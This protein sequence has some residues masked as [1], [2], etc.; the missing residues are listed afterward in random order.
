M[1]RHARTISH[2]E[3]LLLNGQLHVQQHDSAAAELAKSPVSDLVLPTRRRWGN[4]LFLL[5]FTAL[6]LGICGGAVWSLVHYFDSIWQS[7]FVAALLLGGIAFALRY[8]AIWMYRNV[9]VRHF[10]TTMQLSRENKES[11]PVLEWFKVWLPRYMKAQQVQFNNVAPLFRKKDGTT[12]F[13]MRKSD[14]FALSLWAAQGSHSF[15]FRAHDGS[16]SSVLMSYYTKG[17]MKKTGWNN[18]LVAQEYIDLY[19]F[20]PL[21]TRLRHLVEMLERAQQAYGEKEEGV[22]RFQR[23]EWNS[24]KEMWESR[25]ADEPITTNFSSL[26]FYEQRLLHRVYEEVESFLATP[27]ADLLAAGLPLKIGPPSRRAPVRHLAARY[28]LDINIIDMN[29]GQMNNESLLQCFNMA[30]GI[31]LLEDVDN[32][33]AAIGVKSA[34]DKKEQHRVT[35]DGLLNALDGVQRG[36]SKRIIIATTNYP[37]KLMP[38]IRRRG[39][40]GLSFEITYPSDATLGRLLRHHLPSGADVADTTAR[41]RAVETRLGLP[42]PTAALTDIFAKA[43]LRARLP[44]AA[45]DNGDGGAAPPLDAPLATEKAIEEVEEVLSE[46]VSTNKKVFKTIDELLSFLH[47]SD[48]WTSGDREAS[49]LAWERVGPEPPAAPVYGEAPRELVSARLSTGL[50]RQE[51]GEITREPVVSSRRLS[52]GLAGKVAKASGKAE[53]GKAPSSSVAAAPAETDPAAEGEGGEQEAPA[54]PSLLEFSDEEWKR[55]QVPSLTVERYVRVEG[56]ESGGATVYYR[57]VDDDAKRDG[58]PKPY[59]RSFADAGCSSAL[60]CKKLDD[61]QLKDCLS[62]G[63]LGHRMQ[64]LEQFRFL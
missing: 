24:W 26:V 44:R 2:V 56:A 37:E 51:G 13:T 36:A 3:P 1:P 18:E 15:V 12:F 35:L 5:I 53:G 64:L 14:Q 17:E 58:R 39:R 60:L 54:D 4:L 20:D 63:A 55:F 23:R 62:I 11:T 41:L 40:L 32:V 25:G 52:K 49:G 31:I 50:A 59:A 8:A 22:L 28:A 47:L 46:V 43:G 38:S 57:P 33:D 27:S 34:D 30:A 45:A 29:S 7:G 19:I 6:T 9:L 61:H 21:H 42:A 16:C 48:A 10:C